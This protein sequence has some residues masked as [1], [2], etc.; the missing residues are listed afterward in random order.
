M[1]HYTK[2]QW[3]NTDDLDLDDVFMKDKCI[4][5]VI[6]MDK[7]RL[8]CIG[9]RVQNIYCKP[10]AF[11]KGDTDRRWSLWNTGTYSIKAGYGTEMQRCRVFP[12]KKHLEYFFC[13]EAT[14][15]TSDE[16]VRMLNETRLPDETIEPVAPRDPFLEALGQMREE[17]APLSEAYELAISKL[18]WEHGF[19]KLHEG[20]TKVC[21]ISNPSPCN[22]FYN[23]YKQTSLPWISVGKSEMMRMIFD[24]ETHDIKE[25]EMP[26]RTH[27]C[28]PVAPKI[29]STLDQVAKPPQPKPR[30]LLKDVP[31]GTYFRIKDEGG[32]NI[33][34]VADLKH[35][36][37]VQCRF[38]IT[39]CVY[40]KDCE[41][42]KPLQ[43]ITQSEMR[44]VEVLNVQDVEVILTERI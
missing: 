32:E 14:Y 42:Y 27:C 30:T 16:I 5:R 4:Y 21:M 29:T 1:K 3:K 36:P 22:H 41:S 40:A 18:E 44:S 11:R 35:I 13:K 7:G 9:W 2:E 31:Q 17:M 24:L 8:G 26:P 25:T 19:R 34:Q 43:L 20:A 28:D 33:Y 6:G 15:T 39:I 23:F 10:I 38:V 12:S 37:E